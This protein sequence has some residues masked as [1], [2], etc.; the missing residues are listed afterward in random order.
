VAV[1]GSSMTQTKIKL[2]R[3]S[4]S[5]WLRVTVKDSAG[6]RAWSNPIWR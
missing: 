1:H 5:E 2:G 6:K 4:Q 3:V